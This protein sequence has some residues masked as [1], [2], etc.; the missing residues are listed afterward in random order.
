MVTLAYSPDGRR[1]ASADRDGDVRIWD[2]DS[3][4]ERRR[5]EGHSAPVRA[6]AFRPD[7]RVL[8]SAAGDDTVRIWDA[9]TGALHA[10]D[11]DAGAFPVQHRLF[12]R[13]RLAGHR[14]GVSG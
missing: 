13:R 3:G 12:A 5:L 7:G 9:D 14:V 2:A 8:A 11:P 4:R 6:L 1:L 10:H